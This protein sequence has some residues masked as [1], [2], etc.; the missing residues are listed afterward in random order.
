MDIEKLINESKPAAG[1]QQQKRHGRKNKGLTDLHAAEYNEKRRN[2]FKTFTSIKQPETFPGVVEAVAGDV[3]N[4]DSIDQF[5]ELYNL[6]CESVLD[7]FAADN[8][9]LVKKHP[10]NWY[11][12]LLMQLKKN[13]PK[14]TADDI[15]KCCVVWEALKGLLN[16]IGLFI[17]YESFYLLTGI[18]KRLLQNREKLSPAY[19][20]FL[21]KIYND[22]KNALQ[23]E[24]YISP[25]NSVNKI[26]MNKAVY[27]VVEKTE[28]KTIEV[29]HNIRTY[30]NLP[31]F[32]DNEN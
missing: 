16:T 32:G 19:T 3:V 29:N 30:N 22:C 18:D 10:Y 14:I 15:E 9:E 24:I 21:Q 12:Q 11:K 1:D 27:G 20:D 6:T 2:E 7:Q 23:N 31:M 8:P 28:P 4:L 13:T 17:T 26:Y 25:Y 5:A